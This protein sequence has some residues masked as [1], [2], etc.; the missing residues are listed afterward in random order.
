MIPEFPFLLSVRIRWPLR[1]QILMPFALLRALAI[2][3][4]LSLSDVNGQ[5]GEAAKILGIHRETLR[6][7]L[8]RLDEERA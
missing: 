5:R 8:R 2:G 6:E 1:N 3:V 7:K 4:I